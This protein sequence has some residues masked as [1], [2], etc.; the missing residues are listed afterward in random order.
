MTR[1]SYLARKIGIVAFGIF[2]TI[3][4]NFFLFRVL[5][6]DAVASM[7]RVPGG[8]A[9]LKAT[10]LAEFGLDKPLMAQYGDYLYQ[11]MRGNLGVSYS[12]LRPVTEDV[13]KAVGN[14]VP[15]TLLGIT[16]AVLVG[17]STGVL[18][19]YK[20]G[21]A[22]DTVITNVA[23][24]VYSAPTQWI[25]IMLVLAFSA[26]LPASGASDPFSFETEFWPL[27]VDRLRHIVLPSLTLA[28]ACF[29]QYTLVTRSS[30]LA[31]LG[32]DYVGAAKAMGFP[33]GRILFSYAIPNALIPI[34]T[35]IALSMGT[36][37]G[38]SVVIETV[39]SWPGIGRAMY[40][41]ITDRNYPLLQG[42]LLVITVSVI[43]FNLLADI[44]N[45][46]I[47]PRIVE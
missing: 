46:K 9:E 37:M 34:V 29:G 22:T 40:E 4:L 2:A 38:G 27:F 36:I 14:T 26:Y 44:I 10:L 45:M 35:L 31:T 7:A 28:T 43:V 25:A 20:H 16:I 3:T 1:F 12:S 8:S 32:E 18:A 6:G 47:D 30:V 23:T 15:M 13:I 19:A 17:I 5:P 33:A 24:I 42:A 21:T 11:L 39:F 41:A